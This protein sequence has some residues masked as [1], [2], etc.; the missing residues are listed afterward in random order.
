[1][2]GNYTIFRVDETI[3]LHIPFGIHMKFIPKSESTRHF[4]IEATAELINKKGL[5]GTSLSDLENATRLSKGS[6]YGNFRDKEE[7]VS[8]VFDYNLG[9]IRDRTQKAV[10]QSVD[11]REKLL[12][13]IAVYYAAEADMGGCPMQNTAVEADDTNPTLRKKAA[14]GLLQWKLDLEGLIKRGIQA[15]EFKKDTN[16]PETALA[17][18]ALIE[19]GI[20]FGRATQNPQF[21]DSIFT[22]AK[23]MVESICKKG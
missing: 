2:G 18:I 4:I 17:I 19:G 8:A 15:K 12:A 9:R 23:K 7:V 3:C 20:L 10:N 16:A 11:Y 22:V 13:H 5:A 1:M 14:D 6:I 21:T